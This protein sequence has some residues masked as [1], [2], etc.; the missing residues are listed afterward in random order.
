MCRWL[1]YSGTPI[2]LEDLLFKPEN[3]LIRQSL[4]AS[5]SIVPTNGDRSFP[6]IYRDTMPAWNDSNLLSL[7][8]QIHARSFFAHVRASTGTTTSRDNCHP[9]R[10]RDL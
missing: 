8:Q 1:A 6:G 7:S 2:P 5:E 9:F 3:S 4:A 10:H